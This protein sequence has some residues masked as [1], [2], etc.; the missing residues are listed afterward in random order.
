MH[1]RRE[2]VYDTR[3]VRRADIDYHI[4]VTP[5]DTSGQWYQHYDNA[6]STITIEDFDTLD[7]A[8][9]SREINAIPP[10][11]LYSNARRFRNSRRA[12]H[13]YILK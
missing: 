5:L 10:I 1:E 13:Y 4:E 7:S 6:T 8:P 9:G 12:G 11:R 3:H 2:A